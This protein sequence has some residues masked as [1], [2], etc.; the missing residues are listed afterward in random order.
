MFDFI[1]TSN[2]VI[3]GSPTP[4]SSR[5]RPCVY[6]RVYICTVVHIREYIIVNFNYFATKL[7]AC[8]RKRRILEEQSRETQREC[9]SSEW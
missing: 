8:K 2:I 3:I 9:A 1:S 7:R 5:L 4:A 6:A